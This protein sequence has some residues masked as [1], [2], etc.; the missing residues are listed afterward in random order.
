[1]SKVLIRVQ[2]DEENRIYHVT[3]KDCV[4]KCQKCGKEEKV[5]KSEVSPH[6][7]KC[8]GKMKFRWWADRDDI[9]FEELD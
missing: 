3:E 7:C 9:E 8:G 1:M 6:T 2:D 4:Y 5:V